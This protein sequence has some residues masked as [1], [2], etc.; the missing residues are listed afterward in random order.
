MKETGDFGTGTNNPGAGE[1]YDSSGEPPE[2]EEP[3]EE[4]PTSKG[5]SDGEWECND[6]SKCIP[7]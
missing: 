1:N 7:L 2:S 6:G 3:S 4:A 5:C